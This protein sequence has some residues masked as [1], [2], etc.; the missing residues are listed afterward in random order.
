MSLTPSTPD[1]SQMGT[2]AKSFWDRREG[3][4]GKIVLVVAALAAA[5]LLLSFWNL[6]LPFLIGTLE[7]T[8]TLCLDAIALAVLTSPIWSSRV[9]LL[10]GTTFKLSMRW[11]TQILIET[12]PIGILRE[13]VL[14]MKKDAAKLAGAVEKV[15]KS[16]QGL[17]DAIGK[18]KDVILSAKGSAQ[19]A[20]RMIESKQTQVKSVTDQLAALKLRNEI[21][22][23]QLRMQGFQQQAGMAGKSIEQEQAVLDQAKTMYEQLLRYQNLSDY[24]ID[25][26]TQNANML[27]ER[28]KVILAG[29]ESLSVMQKLLGGDTAQTD[30][31][32]RDIDFLEQ[33]ASDVKGAMSNFNRWSDKY[34]TDMDIQNGA[35]ASRG[36]DIFAQLEQKLTTPTA[37]PSEVGGSQVPTET[38][39]D[40]EG[41]YVPVTTDY[42]KFLK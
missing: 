27:E 36:A 29:A 42:T 32:N 9:R 6:I 30:L 31:I 17:V 13:H 7:N 39:R 37:L 2:A 4:T 19:Q 40:S 3:S 8:I 16:V 1:F 14:D 18:N 34:L 22:S 35:A 33:E 20:Q 10:I 41:T 21:N 25:E 38:V 24:K 28:R 5:G 23:L 26:F 11:A 12:D 15:A